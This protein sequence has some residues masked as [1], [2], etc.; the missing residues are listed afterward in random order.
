MEFANQMGLTFDILHDPNGMIRT[1]YQTV[2]VPESFLIDRDGA[3]LKKVIGAT[4]WDGPVNE[5]LIRRLL[6]TR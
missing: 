6:D 1:A 2:A 4:E 5:Q 3:I